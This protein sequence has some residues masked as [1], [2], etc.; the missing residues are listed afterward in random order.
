MPESRGGSRQIADQVREGDLLSISAPRHNF[1]LRRDALRSVL[2]AGGIGLTPLLAMAKALRHGG[3]PFEL[4]VFSRDEAHLPFADTL[5]GFGDN[6]RQYLGADPAQT[7]EAVANLLGPYGF[8]Q[9]VYVCGAPGLIDA[10]TRTAADLGWPDEAVHYEHFSNDREIDA[11]S[12][13]TVELARSALTVEIPAGCSMLAAIRQAGVSL[14]SSCERGACG[15]CVV[16][17]LEGVPDH[18]DVYLNAREKAAGRSVVTCVSRA[19]SQRLVLD[20]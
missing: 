17:V 9:H 1:P 5:R 14:P 4:H 13:F 11:S 20:L 19:N 8:A 6:V 7:A 10:V 12:S 16:N 15:T 18:Q 3:N 2:I